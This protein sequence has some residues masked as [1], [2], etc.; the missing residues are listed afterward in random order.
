MPW[1]KK[2]KG[3]LG[4]EYTETRGDDGQKLSE[5]REREGLLGGKYTETTDPAG[6]KISESRQKTGFFG[7][8]YTETK[9]ADGN[10]ISESHPRTDFL[11]NE[12]TEHVDAS[13]AK[14]GE[15]RD[16]T[17]WLGNKYREHK[18]MAPPK[19]SSIDWG[20]LLSGDFTVLFQIAIKLTLWMFAIVFVLWLI[21]MALAI[22][23]VL[24]PL[25]LGGV[26]VG[27][28]TAF[29]SANRAVYSIPEEV[30][31]EVPIVE[32]ERRG[33]VRIRICPQFLGGVVR[34]NPHL[35]ILLGATAGYVVALSVWPFLTNPDGFT[36]VLLGVGVVAGIVLGTLAGRR[37]MLWQIEDKLAEGAGSSALTRLIAPKLSLGF[38]IPGVIVL[39]GAWVFALFQ[40][41]NTLDFAQAFG[42]KRGPAGVTVIATTPSTATAPRISQRPTKTLAEPRASTA[43]QQALPVDLNPL[44]H[45]N[46]KAFVDSRR[47]DFVVEMDWMARLGAVRCVVPTSALAFGNASVGANISGGA[48]RDSTVVSIP[49]LEGQQGTKWSWASD[50]TVDAPWS[51]GIAPKSEER[52]TGAIEVVAKGPAEAAE[53]VVALRQLGEALDRPVELSTAEIA[54]STSSGLAVVRTDGMNGNQDASKPSELASAVGGVS[55][56]ATST[57]QPEEAVREFVRSR[58]AAEASRSLEAIISNYAERVDYWGNG[59]VDHDFIRKDKA[60]YFERWPVSREEIE[61][62]ISVSGTGDDWVAQFKTRFRVENPSKG[63]VIQGRQEA[64]WS[65]RLI[66]G[67]FRIVAE[68]GQV[69]EKQRFEQTPSPASPS[70]EDRLPGE[71]FPETRQVSLSLPDLQRLSAEDL[72]YAINEMFARHGADFPKAEVKSQFVGFPW[73]RPRPGMELDEIE[74]R[75]FSPLERENLKLLGEA[76][77]TAGTGVAPGAA[78]PA[79]G[80]ASLRPGPKARFVT[81]REL[82]NLAGQSVKD[83]W[84]YGDFVA[85]SISGNTIVMYP[86]WGGGFIRGYTTEIRATFR[87]GV[88]AF[89][90]LDR[91][92]MDPIDSNVGIKIDQSRPL[93]IKSVTPTLKPGTKVRMVVVNAEQ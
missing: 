60:T 61:G 34:F 2:K 40:G 39:A 42:F 1:S 14:I 22:T 36:R 13:G 41:P 3:C 91:L 21:A 47:G 32:E 62:P 82:K 85:A 45:D 18:Q 65:L 33:K 77:K 27:V 52:V 70:T 73:Y 49:I 35:L 12:Y 28:I 92:P 86:A 25:W 17:D 56:Q 7:D 67:S 90:G 29:F 75:F 64:T 81:T 87:A 89:P 54:S 30:L 74:S 24:S 26:A 19:R 9:D 20:A 8:T 5:S 46:F 68:N 59:I 57:G 78:P 66:N 38:A 11:G 43:S 15:S 50:P 10:K 72:R 53:L 93:R 44:L 80:G 31:A 16:R 71:R 83:T 6:R 4:D 23:A 88:P 37:M 84:F 51:A 48:F 63:V 76:R 55:E 79:S 58:L 69:L